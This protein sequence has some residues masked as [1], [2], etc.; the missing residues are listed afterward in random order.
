MAVPEEQYD[1]V[2]IGAGSGGVRASRFA[3]SL[4]GAKVACVELP[5]GFI[6]S[7]A[8][9][10]AGGTCVIRGCVPKKLLVYGAAFSEEFADARGFG[11]ALNGG[12]GGGDTAAA[13]GTAAAAAAKPVH[14]WASLVKLKNKEITRLNTTYGNILKSA[15]VTFIEGRG[16]LADATTV[17]V[18]GADGSKRRLRAKHILV[19][20]GGVVTKIPIEGAEHA[21]ISDDALALEALPPGPIVVLGAGYIATE[22]AGIFR[23]THR[24]PVHIMFRGDKVLR[25]FDEECRDQVQENLTRRGIH[26]HPGC[27]PTRIEKKDEQQYVLHYTDE[28]GEAGQIEC[29]L[30]MMATGRK[31]RVEGLGLEAL[32]VELDSAGAIK[33]D[34]FSRTSVPG[35]WAVGDVT[36]RINLT[37]VALMEGMAFAKSAFGGELTKP[38]YRNVA[39][40]VFCQPPLATVG[41]TEAQAI[42]E[43][44]GN[45]D[46]YVTRF[47]PMK[48]TISGRDEKTLMKLIVHAESD[49]VLGCHMVGPDSAEIM[50]G[51]AIALR[52]GATKAQFD[53][54]VG[55]HPTAAEE[56]VTMRSRTRTVP[57][58][59]TSKL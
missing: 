48:Y 3:A 1:L 44:S 56:F 19:A 2:T 45:I 26:V 7:E 18:T 12:G 15:G 6:A 25:G 37:P 42:K 21:I 4:Y 31:P 14:D 32:G 20:T 50:Q 41:Y 16:S 52:C 39:S 33:V 35:I 47:R 10:G 40:A 17:E 9:G 46:V 38:D 13:N 22:F 5:F 49:K 34:E 51:L 29:G 8:I 57:A 24:H 54:T 23:G 27:K 30:V 43:F 53:A 36:N 55:I 59:G 28:R 58:T 11:W